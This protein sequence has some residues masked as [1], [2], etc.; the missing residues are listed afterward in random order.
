MSKLFVVQKQ[1]IGP[2]IEPEE[3]EPEA[4]EVSG[5]IATDMETA[6]RA[7]SFL[8]GWVEEIGGPVGLLI[9]ADKVRAFREERHE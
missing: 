9:C 3:T 6:L 4:F 7:L 1:P 5:D 8:L 2:P